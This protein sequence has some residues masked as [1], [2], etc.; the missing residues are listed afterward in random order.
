MEMIERRPLNRRGYRNV[1]CPHYSECLDDAIARAWEYW[2]CGGCEY[3]LTEDLD[4]DI[5][6][7][8]NDP[9][10]FYDLPGELSRHF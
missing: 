6:F 5:H 7:A 2:E 9:L 1:L 10:P 4:V 3:R 8:A